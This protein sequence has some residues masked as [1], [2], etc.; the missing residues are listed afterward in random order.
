MM[1]NFRAQCDTQALEGARPSPRG[2]V[3]AKAEG[4][5]PKTTIPNHARK[6]LRKA[7]REGPAHPVG[8]ASSAAHRSTSSDTDPGTAARKQRFAG[9]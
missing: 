8:E 5:P 3:K 6:D 2:D 9:P 4:A 7:A 1:I